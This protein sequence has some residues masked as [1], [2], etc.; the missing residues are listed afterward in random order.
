[1]GTYLTICQDVA[2][3]SGVV[4]TWASISTMASQTGRIQR[5]GEWVNAAHRDI[6]IA[7]D[8]WLWMVEEFSGSITS[9]TQRYSAASILSAGDAARFSEWIFHDRDG[10]YAFSSYLTSDG[11][12]KE[13]ALRYEPFQ[14]FRRAYLWGSNAS[15]TGA[16]TVVSVDMDQQLVFYPTPDDSYTV[17]GMF[18][19][20]PQ[21]L[22]DDDDTPEM[23]A[24]FHDA[25][26][27]RALWHMGLFDEA[28][29]Q[30]PTWERE[31]RR[32]YRKLMSHQLPPVS[33]PGP[34]A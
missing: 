7:Q 4:P 16:P 27:Y 18:Y 22:S 24:Q 25:I 34:L 33:M 5:I 15:D 31:Y 8:Q 2:R 29:A 3:E 20:S 1:M 6:Q 19:K 12:T 32:I 28:G 30:M 23:P 9:G 14:R 13:Q 10:L 11:Q 26:K 21:A 17:R